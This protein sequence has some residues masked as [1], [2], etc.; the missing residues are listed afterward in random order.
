VDGR[1]WPQREIADAWRKATTDSDIVDIRAVH[2]REAAVR[3]L[4]SYIAK[5]SDPLLLPPEHVPTWA[6]ATHGLRMYARFGNL[7]RAIPPEREDKITCGDLNLVGFIEPLAYAAQCGQP[8]AINAL[9][10][11]TRLLRSQTPHP[12][13]GEPATTE[14]VASDLRAAVIHF[15]TE[16]NVTPQVY[17]PEDMPDPP[18]RTASAVNSTPLLPSSSV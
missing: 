7:H 4:T 1:Y 14:S 10:E 15:D 5:T 8:R 13:D 2:S 11:F 18:P 6:E 17:D 3:Y 9:A 16:I 12:D